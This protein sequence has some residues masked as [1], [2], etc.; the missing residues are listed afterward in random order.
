MQDKFSASVVIVNYN[1]GEYLRRCLESLTGSDTVLEIVVV[2]NASQDNSY[3]CVETL[4]SGKHEIKLLCN[5]AN[6]GFATAVNNGVA[7]TSSDVVVLL[8]PDSVV[9]A[10]SIRVLTEALNDSDNAAITGGLVFNED[11][12]EQNGC[13]RREP[14]LARSA[15]KS[16]PLLRFIFGKNNKGSLEMS[17]EPLPAIPVPV[18][19]VSG[20]FMAIRRSVFAEIGGVDSEYFLHCED[21]DICRAVR[22]KGHRVLF[23]PKATVFHQQGVSGGS[24]PYRVEWYKRNGMLRYFSKHQA[25]GF[26]TWHRTLVHILITAHFARS[27]TTLFIKRLTASTEDQPLKTPSVQLSF[28][29]N[30]KTI[31]VTGA[32]SA[33]AGKL[34]ERLVN[35]KF[36]VVAL[37]RSNTPGPKN[38]GVQWFNVE[39]LDKVSENNFPSIHAM[40]HLAPIWALPK[41]LPQLSRLR[42]G[43]II[44]ISSTSV[45]AKKA[46]TDEQE[47]DVASRLAHAEDTVREY[48]DRNEIALTILRATMIYDGVN[49]KNISK[50]VRFIKHFGFFPLT[51]EGGGLRQPVHTNDLVAACVQSMNSPSAIGQTYVISGWSVL[52]Y[53]DMVNELFRSLNKNPK[54]IWVPMGFMRFAMSAIAKVAPGK[55]LSPAMI[56]R[57]QSDLCYSYKKA[58]ADFAYT[59]QIFSIQN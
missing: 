16:I 29:R 40:I 55:N 37:S 10:G 35:E 59:P 22:D 48:A 31:L 32:T 46:G 8:N 21:L 51:G 18:D 54:F 1:S 27:C 7:Q 41:L 17:R 6:L 2:D 47:R 53:K 20:S 33:A 30:A 45:M 19:A 23:V 49:D 38:S 56:D 15:L 11:G 36:N 25:S 57:M 26:K 14:D 5:D 4:D 42:V 28:P 43:R 9:H 12:T 13:R 24:H 39:Y 50:L 44:A 3:A 58:N 34:I 52:S